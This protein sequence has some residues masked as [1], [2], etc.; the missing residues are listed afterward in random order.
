M[1]FILWLREGYA[2]QLEGYSFGENTTGI[3]LEQA[4]F[5]VLHE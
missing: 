1:G 3:L 2:H 4:A 5:E